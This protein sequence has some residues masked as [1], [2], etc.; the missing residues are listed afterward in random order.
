MITASHAPERRNACSG[1]FGQPH[2]ISQAHRRRRCR[3][4]AGPPSES[5]GHRRREMGPACGL[6]LCSSTNPSAPSS[7]SPWD[8]KEALAVMLEDQ[9]ILQAQP[10]SIPALNED[11]VPR[12]RLYPLTKLAQSLA[13]HRCLACFYAGARWGPTRRRPSCICGPVALPV[14]RR[15]RHSKHLRL[16][17]NTFTR[18]HDGLLTSGSLTPR[19]VG[20]ASLWRQSLLP[21]RIWDTR[22]ERGVR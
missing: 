15:S 19:P 8:R 14:G 1:L 9:S 18:V 16:Y 22:A 12:A 2:S 13:S 10:D 17:A 20:N 5:C 3:S 6:P 4:P 7:V 11:D 21:G